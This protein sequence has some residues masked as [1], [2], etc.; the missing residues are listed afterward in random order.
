MSGA[1]Y[2]E[3]TLTAK[4]TRTYTV[5]AFD[6]EEAVEKAMD[7]FGAGS[8][9]DYEFDDIELYDVNQADPYE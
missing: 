4:A 3:V 7:R 2:Y 9:L 6:D 5:V 8:G 1:K